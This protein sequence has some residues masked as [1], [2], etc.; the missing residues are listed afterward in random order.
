MWQNQGHKEL[1]DDGDEPPTTIFTASRYAAPAIMS[2]ATLASCSELPQIDCSISDTS[3]VCNL[4][5]F[6]G[7]PIVRGEEAR[8][9]NHDSMLATVLVIARGHVN[10]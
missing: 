4:R 10:F 2:R 7:L 9:E 8:F 5:I 6:L 1:L 3:F